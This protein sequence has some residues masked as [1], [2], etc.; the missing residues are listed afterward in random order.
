MASL[1]IGSG[2][3]RLFTLQRVVPGSTWNGSPGEAQR[4]GRVL[5]RLHS[6]TSGL[7]PEAVEERIH[8]LTVFAVARAAVHAAKRRFDGPT[9]QSR[10]VEDTLTRL[11]E[12]VD[13]LEAAAYAGGIRPRFA[14]SMATSTPRT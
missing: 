13:D 10:A 4:A 3:E 2:Q 11:L 1:P 8:R 12:I 14:S 5:A 7:L 6:S 9:H